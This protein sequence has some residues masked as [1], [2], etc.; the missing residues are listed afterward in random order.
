MA[1]L[2]ALLCLAAV[3]L[4]VYGVCV[5]CSL[6]RGCLLQ[7]ALL[8]VLV[9]KGVA[10]CQAAGVLYTASQPALK[11]PHCTHVRVVG[12]RLQA[13]VCADA[14][15]VPDSGKKE[16]HCAARCFLRLRFDVFVMLCGGVG[17]GGGGGLYCA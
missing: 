11:H 2:N 7:Q 17:G 8:C 14:G 15:G 3:A 13:A 5:L 16:D 6:P 1:G 10:W 9:V 4:H 12:Q